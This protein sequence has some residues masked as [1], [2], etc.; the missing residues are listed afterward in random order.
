MGT[1]TH[2]HI[3][4][5]SI[6]V[7]LHLSWLGS[8]FEILGGGRKVGRQAKRKGKQT[9]NQQIGKAKSGR[10]RRLKA[11]AG[12]HIN[13]KSVQATS[14]PIQMMTAKHLR[15]LSMRIGARNDHKPKRG[16]PTQGGE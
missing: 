4:L 8:T 3:V 13:T 12:G 14:P 5:H 11:P 2:A 16:S 1:G 9:A 7:T 6:G 10:S 15:G